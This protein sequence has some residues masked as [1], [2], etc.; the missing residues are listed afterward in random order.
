MNLRALRTLVAVEQAGGFAAVTDQVSLSL[1]AVSAQM[2]ALETELQ[3]ELFDR[4]FRPPALT[5]VGRAVAARARRVLA[6]ADAIR[7]LATDDGRLAGRFRVGFVLT[8]SVRLLPSF[9]TRVAEEHPQAEIDIVSGLSAPLMRQLVDGALDA[10]VVTRT[11]DLEAG[12]NF[13]R[14]ATEPLSLA[15]PGGGPADP[16]D[17]IAGGCFVQFA[18]EAGIGRIIA[19]RLRADGLTPARVVTLDTMEAVME[20]VNAGVGFTILPEPDARRYARAGVTV[21]RFGT[22]PLTRDLGVVTRSATPNAGALAV[23]S[24]LLKPGATRLDPGGSDR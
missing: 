9:L 20:C 17:A 3:L 13:E 2:K 7:L 14:I 10:A 19:E 5:A 22:P 1:S 4:R 6:E 12:Q 15:R 8:A 21:E 11:P 24:A 16:R 23:L 18:P